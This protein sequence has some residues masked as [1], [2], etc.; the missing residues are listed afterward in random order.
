MED[1]PHERL[2][3][4][5]DVRLQALRRPRRRASSVHAFDQL[6]GRSYGAAVEQEDR[7]QCPR[8]RP[9]EDD[10]PAVVDHLERAE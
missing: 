10:V 9:A 6:L 5:R 7:E 1:G 3:K 4:S 2:A 8:S